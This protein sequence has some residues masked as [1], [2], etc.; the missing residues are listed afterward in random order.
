MTPEEAAAA[1]DLVRASRRANK[2][3]VKE[4][5]SE[6]RKTKIKKKDKKRAINKTKGNKKKR[7]ST[8]QQIYHEQI[9][10][11]V[12]NIYRSVSGQVNNLTVST[13]GLVLL[14]QK[15]DR[16]APA[17]AKGGAARRPFVLCRRYRR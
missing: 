12:V 4:S 6:K 17:A 14:V 2:K 13:I 8:M 7:T 11:Y 10:S 1:K 15:C 16:L 3:A 9:V 5:N